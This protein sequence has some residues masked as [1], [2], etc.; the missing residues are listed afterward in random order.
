MEEGM[1]I[2]HDIVDRVRLFIELPVE[3]S[4]DAL[5]YVKALEGLGDVKQAIAN[6][7]LDL[8]KLNKATREATERLTKLRA[9]IKLAEGKATELI[10]LAQ[11]GVEEHWAAAKEKAEQIVEDARGQASK[12]VAEAERRAEE[13]NAAL[14]NATATLAA[15]KR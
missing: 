8:E 12:I 1:T 7:E 5:D 6:A 10:T 13:V 2:E 15:A 11:K 3:S 4:A 9:E 14:S